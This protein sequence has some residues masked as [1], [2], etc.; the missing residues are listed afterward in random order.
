MYF[1]KYN[2]FSR[3][4]VFTTSYKIFHK[5]EYVVVHTVPQDIS[6]FIYQRNEVRLRCSY[7]DRFVHIDLSKYIIMNLFLGTR[8][9]DSVWSLHIVY[10]HHPRKVNRLEKHENVSIFAPEQFSKRSFFIVCKFWLVE[11]EYQ[12][13]NSGVILWL[14]FTTKNSITLWDSAKVLFCMLTKGSKCEKRASCPNLTMRT[15]FIEFR[16]LKLFNIVVKKRNLASK[17]STHVHPLSKRVHPTKPRFSFHSFN[18]QGRYY[19]NNNVLTAHSR[20]H[21]RREREGITGSWVHIRNRKLMRRALLSNFI[22]FTQPCRT[23]NKN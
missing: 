3:L 15:K 1:M 11:K 6:A 13:Q 4:N 12:S 8:K 17:N 18:L 7:W 23:A 16:A 9:R 14:N 20:G 5:H 21:E 10:V 19:C 2:H 22:K